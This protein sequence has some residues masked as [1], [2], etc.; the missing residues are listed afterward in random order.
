MG[1]KQCPKFHRDRFLN[2]SLK[3]LKGH[4]QE[5]TEM[6]MSFS[7]RVHAQNK[8]R[9]TTEH[10]FQRYH[11]CIVKIFGRNINNCKTLKSNALPY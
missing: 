5:L 11:T 3:D 7:F 4:N 1:N 2:E 6:N 8:R 9:K 10:Y